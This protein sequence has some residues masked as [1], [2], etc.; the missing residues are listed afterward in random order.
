MNKIG[1]ILKWKIGLAIDTGISYMY[2]YSNI[3]SHA[4]N[5]CNGNSNMPLKL[6]S[7]KIY[8]SPIFWDDLV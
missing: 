4:L 7:L 6:S 5:T 8:Y 2:T 3:I 1:K